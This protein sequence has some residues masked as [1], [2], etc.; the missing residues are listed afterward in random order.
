MA[1]LSLLA[2]VSGSI[3]G[4]MSGGSCCDAR[5]VMDTSCCGRFSRAVRASRNACCA[6]RH[7]MRLA[8]T[9][10]RSDIIS[11]NR[12][13][14]QQ[15]IDAIRY[16]GKTPAQISPQGKMHDIISLSAFPMPRVGHAH[17]FRLLSTA[18]RVCVV[19]RLMCKD[20]ECTCTGS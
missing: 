4:V 12:S 18:A 17:T 5:P 14:L 20:E 2:G 1:V 8:A 10:S 7:L 3:Q 19:P 11:L 13:S 16:C 15:C 6:P 9:S